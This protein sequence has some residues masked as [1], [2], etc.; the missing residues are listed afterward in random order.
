MRCYD[1][2]RTRIKLSYNFLIKFF[3]SKFRYKTQRQN[4]Y[5][6][7]PETDQWCNFFLQLLDMKIAI[8][9]QTIRNYL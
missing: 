5:L 3:S 8:F 2:F 4:I 7:V 6:H 9:H 1:E